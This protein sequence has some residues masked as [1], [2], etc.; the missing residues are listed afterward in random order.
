MR[1]V[2]DDRQ[3]P[4]ER[5][6]RDTAIE[7]AGEILDDYGDRIIKTLELGALLGTNASAGEVLGPV[8]EEQ[9]PIG[10]VLYA[11]VIDG[12]PRG[13]RRFERVGMLGG[14]CKTLLRAAD[15]ADPHL[16]EQMVDRAEAVIDRAHRGAA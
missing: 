1:K 15:R 7:A 14:L 16:G 3:H 2:E 9:P 12:K 8:G 10:R 4:V 11:E 5:L 13:D 6:A